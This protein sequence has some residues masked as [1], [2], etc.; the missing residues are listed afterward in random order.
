MNKELLKNVMR[1]YEESIGFWDF[2]YQ[3]S[4]EDMAANEAHI[5]EARLM[6]AEEAADGEAGVMSGREG[7]AGE[8]GVMSAAEAHI[9]KAEPVAENTAKDN[10][11]HQGEEINLGSPVL[12]AAL[13]KLAMAGNI[14]DYGC[15]DGWASLYLAEAGAEYVTGIEPAISG[16][17]AARKKARANGMQDKTEFLIG[18]GELL[19]DMAQE[20]VDGLFVCNVFDVVPEHVCRRILIRLQRVLKSGA[21]GIVCINPYIEDI[22]NGER[23]VTEITVNGEIVPKHYAINGILR[24]VNRTTEEWLEFFSEYFECIYESSFQFD[25]EPEGY[26]HRMFRI[27]NNKNVSRE[28]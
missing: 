13:K 2:F 28:Y 26:G 14:L 3:R 8:A 1:E 20:S 17:R 22:M 27:V 16:V 6:A 9:D 5:E 12:E 10:D 19:D 21:E 11:N 4:L 15:G 18:M 25:G 23:P 24:L 7:V